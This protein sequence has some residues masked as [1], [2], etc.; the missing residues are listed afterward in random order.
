M[1]E[2]THTGNF[3]EQN[4]SLNILKCLSAFAVICI[5][6]SLQSSGRVGIIIDALI[7][8]AV[9]VFFLISGYYSY[10]TNNNV[11]LQKYKKRAIRLIVLII[12]SNLTYFI[13]D[14]ITG[15]AA[16]TGEDLIKK[17]DV[18]SIFNF[19]I[20]NVSL[21]SGHLWFLNSLLYCYIIYIIM[22]KLEIDHKKLYKYIPILLIANIMI[23]EVLYTMRI[24]TL[25]MYYRNFL[26]T[27]LPFFTLGYLIHDKQEK[28]N[29]KISN[30][31][32]LI[33]IIFSCVLIVIER[34]ST[35]KIELFI[36]TIFLSISLF[37]WSILNPNKLNL[38]ILGW[39]GKNLY[40]H[41]YI[42]QGIV[43][44]LLREYQKN[45]GLENSKVCYMNTVIVFIV[46]VLISIIVYVITKIMCILKN[47]IKK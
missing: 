31:M 21:T 8:F 43:I 11:S 14:I 47:K 46:T 45:A 4:K 32:I 13:F 9:P 37:V 22:S 29:N 27:G 1:V 2:Y 41:I 38:K 12:V 23:G 36:G 18:K 3:S 19:L 39:I 42:L 30:K 17:L 16:L 26:F 28:I 15:K 33:T 24:Y 44:E 7:R 34:L 40:T 35:G 10:F 5:H 20:L 25:S 6:C